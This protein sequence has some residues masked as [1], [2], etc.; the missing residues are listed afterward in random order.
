MIVDE[1]FLDGNLE[2]TR[3]APLCI[4]HRVRKS[5]GN[6]VLSGLLEPIAQRQ[7]VAGQGVGARSVWQKMEGKNVNK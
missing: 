7:K 3:V 6:L 5:P 2:T 1:R 4:L